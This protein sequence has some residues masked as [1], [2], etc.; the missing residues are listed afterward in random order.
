VHRARVENPIQNN[1][2]S[3]PHQLHHHHTDS[4][5]QNRASSQFEL[6]EQLDRFSTR[7]NTQLQRK[8]VENTPKS[9]QLPLLWSTHWPPILPPPAEPQFCCHA[10]RASI[11]LLRPQSLISSATPAE[12]QSCYYACRASILLPRLQ[13]LN[14]TT[15]PAEPHS[16]YYHRFFYYHS[17]LQRLQNLNSSPHGTP[18]DRRIS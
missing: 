2:Y 17:P 5:R 9:F 16:S 15:A 11:L 6:Y 18:F 1:P 10:C 7:R 12:P 8:H 14:P 4:K 3:L 13:S